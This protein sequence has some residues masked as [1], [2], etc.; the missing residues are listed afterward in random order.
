VLI[1][2]TIYEET[3]IVNRSENL[4][5]IP[6]GLE[7]NVTRCGGV[8]FGTAE[9]K[10]MWWLGVG[11]ELMTSRLQIQCLSLWVTPPPFIALSCI[12]FLKWQTSC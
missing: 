4:L 11:F 7:A 1:G 6:T 12:D 9:H 2:D 8:E 5:K 3:N 10:F